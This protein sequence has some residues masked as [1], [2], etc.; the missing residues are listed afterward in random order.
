[1][2]FSR[3]WLLS[4][5]AFASPTIWASPPLQPLI[6]R[7]SLGFVISNNQTPSSL[8]VMNLTLFSPLCNLLAYFLKCPNL[9]PLFTPARALMH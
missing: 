2:T 4:T 6:P 3:Q 9:D 1:M 8:D 7:Q 5:L